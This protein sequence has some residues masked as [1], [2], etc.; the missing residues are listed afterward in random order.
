MDGVGCAVFVFGNET[1]YDCGLAGILGAPVSDPLC[2][3]RT[4]KRFTNRIR[5][6]L[7]DE[8]ERVYVETT[9]MSYEFTRNIVI[10]FGLGNGINKKKQVKVSYVHPRLAVITRR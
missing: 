6:H 4:C 8:K 9:F 2:R 1:A 3:E 7:P 5:H 10:F